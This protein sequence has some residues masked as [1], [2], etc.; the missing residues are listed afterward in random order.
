[1]TIDDENFK[2]IEAK[3]KSIK[4]GWPSALGQ[5]CLDNAIKTLG[6]ILQVSH[7][8]RPSLVVSQ[9]KQSIS[10]GKE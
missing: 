1:M 8:E 2:T 7:D 9:H 10:R 5:A 6:P 4:K 3:M